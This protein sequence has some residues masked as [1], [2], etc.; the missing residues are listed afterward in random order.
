MTEPRTP[1]APASAPSARYPLTLLGL[2][3]LWWTALAIAPRYRLDWLLENLLVL[4]AVPVLVLTYRKLRFSDL[5]Y[6]CLFVFFVLHE[7]GAHY[8]YSEVP[9]EDWSRALL[10]TGINEAL[11][12]TRNHYD[13]LLHFLYGVLVL[14]AVVELFEAKAPPRG[15]WAFWMP[16]LFMNSHA[17]V[18][19]TVEWLAAEAFGG[20]LGTAYLGTQGDAWDAQKDM[21][22][23]FAGTLLAMVALRAVRRARRGSS[24]APRP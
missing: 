10:G 7:V 1:A 6:T 5:A 12:W 3:L 14:P 9:Y 24:P 17:V 4:V 11:G 8:T 20:D 15:V 19:E 22:L 18:Y 13:R 21:A 23:A 2:F 16:V